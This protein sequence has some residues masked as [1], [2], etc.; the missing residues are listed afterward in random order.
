MGGGLKVSRIDALK[1][2][3]DEDPADSFSRYALAMEHVKAGDLASAI[4]EFETVVRND[5]DYVATYYQLAKAHERAGRAGDASTAYRK[6]I[7]VAT[8]L[9]DNHARE[10]LTA[11][12]ELLED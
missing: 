2:F 1:G 10:E 12:L 3:L 8:R 9:N 11:A 4:R 7:A 6:G 5:P